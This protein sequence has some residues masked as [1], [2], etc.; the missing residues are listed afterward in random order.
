MLK[1]DLKVSSVCE[2]TTELLR[3]HDITAVMVDLD[4]TLV[5]SGSE[6]I[7]QEIREWMTGLV[8]AGYPLL[9]LSNGERRRVAFWAAEFGI[10]GFPLSGKPFWFAFRRGLRR[11]GATPAQTLM[12][13]DQLF[14]DVLGANLLG[15]KTVLVQPLSPGKLPHTRLLRR[16]E[17]RILRRQAR[18]GERAQREATVRQARPEEQMNSAAGGPNGNS[19]DR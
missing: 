8:S 5:P 9:I 19:I 15:L 7:R 18:S 2:I 1:P 14:T 12:V 13:G 4:D 6:V 16:L 3:R 10:P 17:A 11:L